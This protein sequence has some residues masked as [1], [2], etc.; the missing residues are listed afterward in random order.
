MPSTIQWSRKRGI[1]RLN[2][3]I[4]VMHLISG[5]FGIRTK[6]LNLSAVL[7]TKWAN[8]PKLPSQFHLL[9]CLPPS[10][11]YYWHPDSL[12]PP[13]TREISCPSQEGFPGPPNLKWK[14]VSRRRRKKAQENLCF[15]LWTFCLFIYIFIL[16]DHHIFILFTTVHLQL[17]H[18]LID[19]C[20]IHS[21][22]FSVLHS[23]LQTLRKYNSSLT[24][25]VSNLLKI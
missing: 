8:W 24:E 17:F 22:E 19:I 21:L 7:F 5:T 9:P 6:S 14:P 2:V 16:S 13:G 3:L 15:S 12:S 18:F 10:K 25:V 11:L 23:S 1:N 4:S 20:R